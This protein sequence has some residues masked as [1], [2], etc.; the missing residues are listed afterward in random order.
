MLSIKGEIIIYLRYPHSL[1]GLIF[2]VV[3][4]SSIFNKKETLED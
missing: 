3:S 1:K 4:A 2:K